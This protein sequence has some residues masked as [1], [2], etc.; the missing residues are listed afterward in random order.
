MR[1]IG[2]IGHLGGGSALALASA[3]LSH[4]NQP[5]E[6]ATSGRHRGRE[7]KMILG[8][9]RLTLAAP[10]LGKTERA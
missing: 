5:T 6:Q 9:G 7:N 4:N 2:M 1:K 10:S 3:I 8:K